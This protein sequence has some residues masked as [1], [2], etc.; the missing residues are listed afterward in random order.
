MNR[1]F[2]LG[3]LTV[4]LVLIA[5]AEPLSGF[6]VF[7]SRW[8]RGSTITMNLQLVGGS[9][10]SDGSANFNAVTSAAMSTWNTHLNRVKFAAGGGTARADGDLVNQVFQDSSY[11]GTSFGP[12]TLAVTTR[13]EIGGTERAEADIV[14]NTAFTWDSYRGALRSATDM[15]RV[16]LHE[17]GHALGLDHPDTNGQGV[18]ALMNSTITN[19]DA[20]TA[21]DTA[22]AASL[23][24]P[25]VTSNVS[26]PPRNEPAD[27]YNQLSGVYEN[28]LSAAR[29]G[30]Y[31]NAEGT[32]IWVTEYARQRV[33]QCT[34]DGATENTIDQIMG[35]GGPFVC[36]LTPAGTIG[37]PPR[38]DTVLFMDS[39]EN[40]YRTAL[41]M[42]QTT[43]YV[44]NEGAVVWILEYLRY[45]LN[46]CNHGDAVT[47]VFQQ[48]RGLGVQPVCT[49]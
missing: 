7:G 14:F 41:G 38:N 12:G 3:A 25:N 37:F 44:N 16:A 15:R 2:A 49:A 36:A 11:Y 13:W 17:L 18:T 20:L 22:V 32:V 33:G 6:V 24:G 9:G 23:Y 28:E 1:R 27:F 31:V 5:A 46:G 21:D 29:S 26:F 48:I 45:R 4:V 34:H 19:L 47:K 8:P 10:L 30:T 43:T 40:V 35:V 39:L 42:S